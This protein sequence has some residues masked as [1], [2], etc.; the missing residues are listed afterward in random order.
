VI[1][2]EDV[3]MAVS[4]AT[5][6]NCDL[7]TAE[8]LDIALTEKWFAYYE[9]QHLEYEMY[10]SP[11]YAVSAYFCYATQSKAHIRQLAKWIDRYCSPG[12]RILDVGAGIGATSA[13]LQD[14]LPHHQ[15]F[16][17]NL[18][19]YQQTAAELLFEK[20]GSKV[21][22]VEDDT[23][24][25]ASVV[26]ALE[27]MEHFEEPALEMQRLL[28]PPSVRVFADVSSFQFS[29]A[30]HWS[31]YKFGGVRAG[32][33]QARRHYNEAIRNLRFTSAHKVIEGTKPFWNNRP[34]VW[35]RRD[36]V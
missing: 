30:G 8:A 4:H 17:S 13:L 20:T 7:P 6:I 14:L 35:L 28:S 33:K 23:G 19:G 36:M 2:D 16:Y 34:A 21:Q 29:C 3:M 18:P 32:R 9:P 22:I 15:V 26:L 27:Y 31:T 1:N 11:E 25:G 5:G 24:I 12:Q 10:A